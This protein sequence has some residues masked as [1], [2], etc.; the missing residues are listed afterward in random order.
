MSR[1]P[2]PLRRPRPAPFKV[3]TRLRLHLPQ[4]RGTVTMGDGTLIYGDGLEVEVTEV[5]PGR[6][7]TGRQLRDHDGLMYYEDTGEPILDETRDGYSV[8][9]VGGHG[10]IIWPDNKKDWEVI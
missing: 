6:Q 2:D 10:R 4:G 3:G 9:Y 8:Y 5:K 7:G 1:K